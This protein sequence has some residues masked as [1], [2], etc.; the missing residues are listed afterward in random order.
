MVEIIEIGPERTAEVVALIHES[1]A[2][3]PALDP[4]A[5]AMAET[6][7]SVRPE[8]EE[9]GGLLALIEGRPVGTLLFR[10]VGNLLGLRRVGVLPEVRHHGVA[11]QLAEKA[12]EVAEMRMC[13]G[14]VLEAR[15]ELPRTVRFWH[16]Q[17]YFEVDAAGPRLQMVKMLPVTRKL[18]TAEETRAMGASIGALLLPG[19]L[20]ILNGELGAGK[21]TLTQGIAEGLNVR[22]PITSPTFVI[23][24]VHPSLGVGPSLVHVDAYRLGG[25]AELDD[26]DLDTDIESAVTVVEWG[27]DVAESLA[28]SR[29]LI[30]MSRGADD[31]RTLHLTPVG[32]RWIDLEL[33]GLG[34]ALA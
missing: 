11:P 4:P 6:E 24:R 14:L 10:R 28:G 7:E 17:G 31:V 1:F 3:R 21:T 13:T 34:A 26:L 19:D 22:G 9:H 16:R 20:V 8:L 18:A 27:A 25:A 15:Q 23:A 30:E 32:R 2:G 12:A 33:R 5:T 29:L